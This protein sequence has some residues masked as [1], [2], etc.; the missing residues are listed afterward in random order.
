MTKLIK[1]DKSNYR[2]SNDNGL[3]FVVD[4]IP[5]NVLECAT[6]LNNVELRLKPKY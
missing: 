1:L 3:D 6:S 4:K 5:E 2:L